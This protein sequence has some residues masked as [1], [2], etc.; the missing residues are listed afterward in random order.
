MRS[1]RVMVAKVIANSTCIIH[2][3]GVKGAV[4]GAP[5]PLLPNQK[6]VVASDCQLLMV[7]S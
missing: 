1:Q 3:M 4:K 6:R 5:R 2:I 7:V